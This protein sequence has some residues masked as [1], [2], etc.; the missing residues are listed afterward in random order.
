MN[1]IKSVVKDG[2]ITVNGVQVRTKYAGTIRKRIEEFNDR[3]RIIPINTYELCNEAD[4]KIFEIATKQL[5]LS[6]K[7]SW[8]LKERKF[9][10]YWAQYAPFAWL[11]MTD[12]G[13]VYTIGYLHGDI[14]NGFF[15]AGSVTIALIEQYRELR[16]EQL[17]T[18]EDSDEGWVLE[19]VVEILTA[20]NYKANHITL[21]P[22]MEELNDTR[23][24]L[25]GNNWINFMILQ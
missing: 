23:R 22:E 10:N 3:Y 9:K 4:E 12:Q 15:G 13:E 20:L 5:G 11:L 17:E 14:S 19:P 2:K 18:M 8:I 24:D 1:R 7:P 16:E 6:G 25:P 21:T